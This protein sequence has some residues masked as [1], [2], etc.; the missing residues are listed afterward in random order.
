MKSL[1]HK[2]KNFSSC[3]YFCVYLVF[4]W[5]GI[6]KKVLSKC[7]SWKKIKRNGEG[8]GYIGGLSIEGGAQPFPYYGMKWVNVPN[9]VLKVNMENTRW[10]ELELETSERYLFQSFQNLQQLL[11][12][13][14]KDWNMSFGCYWDKL[15]GTLSTVIYTFYM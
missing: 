12:I 7:W 10:L 4:Y 8:G 9:I 11:L 1:K 2:K 14:W 13:T 5:G 3:I 15:K 6:V